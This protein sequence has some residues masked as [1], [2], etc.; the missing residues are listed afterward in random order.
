M[1]LDKELIFSDDQAVTVDA[2]STV[3]LNAVKAGGMYDSAWLF[4]KVGPIAFATT[5]SI[6]VELQTAT[7]LAFT[8]PVILW[9]KNF[10][11]AAMTAN[12]ILARI[13]VPLGVLA[14]LRMYYDVNTSATAGAF[15]AAI[16]P[17]VDEAV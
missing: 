14:Y 9:S 16:V 8:T 10:L 13:R 6:T 12:A 2:A 4:V 17:D 5:V 15:Y 11:V 3:V 7:D 1:I